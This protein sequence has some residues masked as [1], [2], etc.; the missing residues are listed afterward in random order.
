MRLTAFAVVTLFGLAYAI[1][2]AVLAMDVDGYEQLVRRSESRDPKTEPFMAKAAISAY[3]A[4]MAQTIQLAQT[5]SQAFQIGE[6]KVLCF[7]SQ[8]RLTPEL[9]RGALDAELKSPE[10]LREA[11]GPK[12]REVQLPFVVSLALGRMFP[13]PTE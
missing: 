6:R 11:L 2:P 13:C 10:F 8:V 4:G 1:S 7:P 3:F 5:G 9:L 12:W